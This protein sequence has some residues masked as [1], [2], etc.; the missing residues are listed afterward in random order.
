M[1]MDDTIPWLVKT[2]TLRHMQLYYKRI[3]GMHQDAVLANVARASLTML[4]RTIAGTYAARSYGAGAVKFKPNGFPD[5]RRRMY[6]GKYKSVV[7][8]RYR[9]TRGKDFTQ[10]NHRAGIKIN[11]L[12]PKGYTWHHEES[13]GVLRLVDSAAHAQ[14]S[15]HLGGI[16]YHRVWRPNDYI[17]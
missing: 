16:F 17:R 7:F 13:I 6:N 4:L 14:I 12:K 3:G 2:A 5:F 15:P 1:L 8:V 11:R 9:G 10:A